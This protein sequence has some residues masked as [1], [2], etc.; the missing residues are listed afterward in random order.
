MQ[1][2]LGPLR[3]NSDEEN[4][5][6]PAFSSHS[7]CRTQVAEAHGTG[8]SLPAD[9]ERGPAS[10]MMVSRGKTLF[11]DLFFP[12]SFLTLFENFKNNASFPPFL[13]ITTK[14]DESK[15][16]SQ[17]QLWKWAILGR[18]S[19]A[20]K[21]HH[22][23]GHS[24]K[25]KHSAGAGLQSR[26]SAHCH[27]GGTGWS[28]RV[29]VGRSVSLWGWYRLWGR[30]L[31]AYMLKLCPVWLTVASAACGSKCGTLGF[32]SDTVSTCRSLYPPQVK[33]SNT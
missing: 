23:H 25:G 18:V 15:L 3:T 8:H 13:S 7:T 4:T 16:Q 27:R 21:R 6:R 26:G 30:A 29:F 12:N 22:G 9:T 28:R 2:L 11:P 19:S 5:H 32:F 33:H 17:L 24:S 31:R 10:R 1:L 14:F 20:V